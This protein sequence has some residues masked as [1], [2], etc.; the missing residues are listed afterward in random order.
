MCR[1][2]A[3]DSKSIK[4]CGVRCRADC[5][6][7]LILRDIVEAPPS[8]EKENPRDS[9]GGFR[10]ARTPGN[11]Q[12]TRDEESQRGRRTKEDSSATTVKES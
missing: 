9:G 4:M 5:A 11:D 10:W 1:N 6:A 8:E 7:I 12:M 2:G 3:S